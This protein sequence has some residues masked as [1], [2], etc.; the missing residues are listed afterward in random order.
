[1]MMVELTSVSSAVLPVDDLADHL[2]LSRG[3]ADDG[4]QDAQLEACLRAA[5]STI[6]AR[7]G[8]A[9]FERR[10]ALTL[11]GWH[12]LSEHILPLAPVETIDSVKIINRAGSETLID[13]DAYRLRMDRHRPALIANATSLPNPSQG[14]SIEIEFTAGF[15][16]QWASIPGD[17]RQA[18]LILA[19]AYWG[20]DLDLEAG[21]PA[22]VSVLL[23]PHRP[24][25]LR[26][27]AS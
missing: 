22:P 21:M 24:L 7:I 12:G 17:L 19:S 18:V 10:F 8:K 25:R 23:E 6:E 9:L 5:L 27:S 15:G 16:D 2:R 1:M 3:F 4:V 20:Q 13:P 14:G 11:T 26:G